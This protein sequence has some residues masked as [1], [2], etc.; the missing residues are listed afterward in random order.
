MDGVEKGLP[1]I[2]TAGPKSALRS[3]RILRTYP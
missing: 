1:T 3:L 2:E